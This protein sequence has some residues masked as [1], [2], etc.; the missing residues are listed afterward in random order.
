MTRSPSILFALMLL[1][2]C[3]RKNENAV[4]PPLRRNLPRVPVRPAPPV[5]LDLDVQ[6]ILPD[7]S[8]EPVDAGGR[9][10]MGP[11]IR[12][13]ILPNRQI[14]LHT[15]D[16]WDGGIHQTYENCS[17]LRNALPSLRRTVSAERYAVL[18]RV[19]GDVRPGE[20]A[21]S[22]SPVRPALPVRPAPVRP[23][24]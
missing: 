3:T 15:T 14:E 8:E 7:A 10:I 2:A 23:A 1:V 9:T 17:F 5:V 20:V 11:G 18:V 13:V 24:P 16:Q 6:T 4:P 22:A 12:A 19:C 21:A